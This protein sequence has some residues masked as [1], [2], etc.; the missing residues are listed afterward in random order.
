[1]EKSD[2]KIG[3]KVVRSKGD[4]V[5]GR[6]GNIIAILENDR[7]QVDWGKD[8]KSKVNIKVIELESIPYRIIDEPV[9]RDNKYYP[10]YYRK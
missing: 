8:G 10:K 7:V 2:V 3:V 4:Y 5:V 6:V 1:M 9:G